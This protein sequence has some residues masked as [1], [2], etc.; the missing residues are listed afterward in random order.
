M[1]LLSSVDT[2]LPVLFHF[3][4][5]ER[6]ILLFCGMIET[7]EQQEHFYTIQL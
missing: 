3:V 7:E 2:G 1:L 4:A 5:V 6:F